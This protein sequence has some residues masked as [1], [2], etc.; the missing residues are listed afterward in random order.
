MP[1]S[2]KRIHFDKFNGGLNLIDGPNEVP[3]NDSPDCWNVTIDQRGGVSKRLGYT[4]WNTSGQPAAVI[5]NGYYSEAVNKTIWQA[6]ASLYA[7]VGNGTF[8]S[9]IKTFSDSSRVGMVD[10]AGKVQINHPVDGHF[11]YDG[12][13]FSGAVSG[14]PDGNQ[15]AVWQNKVWSSGDPALPHRLSFC[16]PGDATNWTT[17][18]AGTVDVRARNDEALTALIPSPREGLVVFKEGT[19]Y[20]VY[21]SSTGAYQVIDERNGCCSGI[22]LTSIFG[23]IFCINP[24]GIFFT[25]G[26]APLQLASTKIQPF[27]DPI[28]LNVSQ[29]ANWAAG[30][31][32][33]HRTLYFSVSRAGATAN[34]LV[35]ELNPVEGWIVP[36]SCAASC[37]VI[38]ADDDEKLLGASPTVNGQVYELYDDIG[39]DDGS[40][41]ASR[42]QTAWYTPEEMGLMR[43]RR[44]L[45]TGRGDFSLYRKWDY[46]L[47]DGDLF[48]VT[49]QETASS[50]DSGFLWSDENSIWGPTN[51]EDQQK[52]WSLGVGRAVSFEIQETSTLTQTAPPWLDFTSDVFGAWAIY[53]L[54]GQYVPL[55]LA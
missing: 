23:Q 24:S 3:A 7:E 17:G 29:C 5:K 13:T 18:G 40:S 10:F 4:K 44:L 51:Y 26:I 55:G 30:Y 49:L 36:H 31:R 54:N 52:L 38:F 32:K 22:G 11:N 43:L 28:A 8:G 37:Y 20:R 45:V 14:G 6:G 48:P 27:F 33:H 39:S 47:G 15:L 46:T 19:S 1:A 2:Y 21:D 35:F 42:F 41:I 53:H 25:D 50:W 12:T 9:A 16:A 34:N